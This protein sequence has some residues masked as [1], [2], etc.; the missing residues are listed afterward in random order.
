MAT[1]ADMWP[2]VTIG[3][4]VEI[5]TGLRCTAI[6][7]DGPLRG[8]MGQFYGRPEII[9]H[10]ERVYAPCLI[11]HINVLQPEF[12]TFELTAEVH[13]KLVENTD[14]GMDLLVRCCSMLENVS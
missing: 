9:K 13:Y 14:E 12:W 6:F 2:N 3:C 7:D 10:E 4:R 11:G 1:I 8:Q 5:R